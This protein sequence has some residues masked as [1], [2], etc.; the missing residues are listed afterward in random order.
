[1]FILCPKGSWLQCLDILELSERQD[2]LRFQ[3]HTLKL[4]CAVCALGNNRVAHALCSHVDQA[5]LLYAMES[6]ELPGPLRAGYYDLLLAMHLDAAQRARASMSTEFIIPMTDATKA[7]TLFPDGGRA[8]GPPGVGPSACLRPQPHFAEP[9]FILADGAG[10]APLS[11]GIPLGTLGTRAIRML[12][13]AVAGGG[14]HTRDPVGGSV[15]F[16]L[17]PV[18]KL[19]SALLAVGAL[20]DADVRRVLRMIEPRLFGDTRRD[21]PEHEEEE[22][23]EE[24]A[25]RKAIE[26][27]EMEE[28]EEEKERK[29]EEEEEALEEGLLRMKLPESVKLE[30][31]GLSPG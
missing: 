25:R 16:Q 7:I 1:M 5:Q 8:P 14:P 3:W 28:E 10:R 19:V 13:E 18:L 30:V 4:Y 31:R 23:E 17:V 15:E 24:E 11:P 27:G 6:A 9:C 22:E 29:E 20:G 21:A 12:A 2:L 26:A